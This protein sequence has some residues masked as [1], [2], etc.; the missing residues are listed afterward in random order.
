MSTYRVE[1]RTSTT[2]TI[3]SRTSDSSASQDELSHHA[4]TLSAAGATGELVLVD[5]VTGEGVAR[6]HLWD[7]TRQYD[8]DGRT[9]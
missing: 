3:V 4:A 2:L 9:R 7:E 1:H 6:R 8:G 5:E